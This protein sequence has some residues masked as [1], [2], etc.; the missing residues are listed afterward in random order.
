MLRATVL[1]VHSIAY[2]VKGLS[3]KTYKVL[4]SIKVRAGDGVVI[5]SGII[6][7]KEKIKI[8]ENY[9]V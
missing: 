1:K 4:S 6:I 2:T 5:Q 7:K 9:D 8:P 3:G